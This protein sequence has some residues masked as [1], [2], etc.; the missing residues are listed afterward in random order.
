MLFS[1]TGAAQH[2]THRRSGA[3]S[4]TW[5]V[6][7]DC[8]RGATPDTEPEEPGPS[9]LTG[10]ADAAGGAAH[11]V[12][13]HGARRLPFISVPEPSATL[14]GSGLKKEAP[15][16]RGAQGAVYAARAPHSAAATASAREN[17]SALASSA[18][19]ASRHRDPVSPCVT[20]AAA[21]G[22][23]LSRGRPVAVKRIFIQ[24]ND[25]G[26]RDVAATVLREVTLHRFISDTQAATL[27][28]TRQE[29]SPP[30]PPSPAA[31]NCID[32]SAR[33]AR[34]ERVVEAPH[35]EMC[36]VMER[37]ATNLERVVL[38]H[39]PRGAPNATSTGAYK[40]KTGTVSL[41]GGT[42]EPA[43]E[44]RPASSSPVEELPMTRY[45]MRRLL[46]V[47]C[48][49]HETCGVVHRDLKLSNVLVME[50][51]GLR[52]A[53]F[54]SARFL[55]PAPPSQ[56]GA[57]AWRR[58]ALLC[59]PPSMRTTLHY[60]PPEVLLGDQACRP[61]ADVWALGV[62]FAQLLLRRGL[63]FA[64]SE[65]DLL[66]A[67][68]KL[69]GVP[70]CGEAPAC[71]PSVPSPPTPPPPGPPASLQQQ[72]TEEEGQDA[73]RAAP[74]PA[75]TVASLPF[76]FHSGVVPADG[77]DLLSRMLEQQPEHRIT[78][79]AALQ[80]PFLRCT[81]GDDAQAEADPGGGDDDDARGRVLWREKVANTL[82][83]RAAEGGAGVGGGERR[84]VF[85]GLG[86]GDCSSDEDDDNDDGVAPFRVNLGGGYTSS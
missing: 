84:P 59:T 14:R 55:P 6:Y 15:I 69:L 70:T 44:A 42:A 9:K 82:R 33:V 45:L 36:L 18:S 5:S 71:P 22:A 80:H 74:P 38:P 10:D 54:G 26:A 51:G 11:V 12:T 7:D 29:S 2:A 62:I 4:P 27:A 20:D 56:A 68:H 30:P 47:L 85:V 19:R 66:G 83:S 77:L 50:D 86:L 13:P 48:F 34:L 81:A 35:K 3:D 21:V 60:R 75:A 41:F 57:A 46:R 52:L 79:R 23:P 32:E 49:L 64:E 67:I 24:S 16:R 39:G 78:V 72:E 40:R 61:A 17:G 65:L 43:P 73:R 63:F 28:L 31:A 8:W 76:K 58:E 37:A 25:F 53:D 1:L